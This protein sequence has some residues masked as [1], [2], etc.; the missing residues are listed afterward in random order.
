MPTSARHDVTSYLRGAP[1]LPELQTSR[2]HG[3]DDASVDEQVGARDEG[4]VGAEQERD[5]AGDAAGDADTPVADA[6]IIAG[7][8]A[9]DSELSSRWPIPVEM[10]PGLML[11]TRAPRAP[12]RAL[13][14]STS[15]WLARLANE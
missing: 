3:G 8:P 14:A 10:T 5:G 2:S 12:Q 6:A 13:A 9:Q 7:M 4:G 1:S 11:L 15:S